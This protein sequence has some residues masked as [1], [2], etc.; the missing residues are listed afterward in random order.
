LSRFGN[1]DAVAASYDSTRVA[2]GVDVLARWLE[3][4][5]PP[6]AAQRVLDAG[7]GT[8]N[9]LAAL[10]GRVGELVGLDLS[11]R[12][13]ARARHKLRGQAQV[14]RADMRELPF[15]DATF[16]GVLAN[17][18]LHH[19]DQT[20]G[21]APFPGAD[22]FLVEVNRVLRSGGVLLM[23]TCTHEQLRDGFWWADLVSEATERATLRYAP[24][25]DVAAR[26]ERY[27]LHVI[28]S[29]PDRRSVLQGRHYLDP[30]GP[31]RP[32]WRSGDSTWSLATEAE[33]RAALDR[34]ASMERHGQIDGYIAERE[35]RRRMVGQLTYVR[36]RKPG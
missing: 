18:V 7:C 8:G 28:S 32:S 35:R 26:M 24:L 27:G 6:P 29:E 10:R 33:L 22:R 4:D 20:V 13:V 2:V 19:L 9:Y 17:M 3:R 5:G 30:T 25:D 31:T 36:A 12:M 23:S 16:D 15:A 1:Y 14:V 21:D 34:L 11:P